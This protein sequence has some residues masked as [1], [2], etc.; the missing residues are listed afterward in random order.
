[1]R[2][3]ESRVRRE[4]RGLGIGQGVRF[5][6]ARAAVTTAMNRARVPELELRYLTGHAPGDILNAYLTLD[7]DGAMGAYFQTIRPLL[8][9]IAERAHLLLG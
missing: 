7:P 6:D 4:L 8:D 2:W 3:V 1:V 9:V 5:Y